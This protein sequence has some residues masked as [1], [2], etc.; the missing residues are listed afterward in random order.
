MPA[1]L[2]VLLFSPLPIR[3]SVSVM[4]I[5]P[6]RFRTLKAELNDGGQTVQESGNAKE[7]DVLG[8]ANAR[9]GLQSDSGYQIQRTIKRGFA[10]SSQLTNV[11]RSEFSP[12][13]ANSF[14]F[15][16]TRRLEASD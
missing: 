6:G 3:N 15:L 2:R 4:L 16:P 1:W 14:T 9:S 12:N 7:Q 11:L 10:D 13:Y 5:V 8:P